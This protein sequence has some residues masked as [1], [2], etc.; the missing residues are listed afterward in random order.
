MGLSKHLGRF[1]RK[2]KH[3][4][5]LEELKRL[6][7][8]NEVLKKENHKLHK[9]LEHLHK[10]HHDLPDVVDSDLIEKSA[11][12]TT[13][14]VKPEEPNCYVYDAGDF[15]IYDCIVEAKKLGCDM[16]LVNDKLSAMDGTQFIAWFQEYKKDFS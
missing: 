5:E 3:A 16:R 13:T 7:H 1:S 4:K 10:K 15:T 12:T 9:K 8:E 14:V 6:R 11:C 2:K